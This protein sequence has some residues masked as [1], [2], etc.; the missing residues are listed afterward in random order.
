M[1]PGPQIR[2]LAAFVFLAALAGCSTAPF[3]VAGSDEAVAEARAEGAGMLPRLQP[4]AFGMCYSPMLNEE[5][6]I[7]EEAAYECSGGRLVRMGEDFFWNQCSLSQPHRV[8][9]V[10]YPPDKTKRRPT[11]QSE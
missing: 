10:C 2:P 8:N 4:F 11:A 7:E 6:E 9:F 1:M 3:S 5:P